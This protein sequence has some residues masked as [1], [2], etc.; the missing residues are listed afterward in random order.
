MC[1]YTLLKNIW[2]N[3]GDFFILPSSI[4]EVIVIADCE[5]I[6]VKELTELVQSVN[7]GSV[8]PE[9]KLTDSVYRFDGIAVRR[10]ID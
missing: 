3:I 2:T 10:V 5:D 6:E 8:A 4:H 9:D 7:A 1:D